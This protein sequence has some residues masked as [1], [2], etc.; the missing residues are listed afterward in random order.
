MSAAIVM[1]YHHFHNH[2][3]SADKNPERQ[4]MI[5]L[6]TMTETIN[7]VKQTLASN[8]QVKVSELNSA[9]QETW[10]SLN[11]SPMLLNIVQISTNS[12]LMELRQRHPSL[13]CGN[14]LETLLSTQI[15]F[16]QFNLEFQELLV[17]C[18]KDWD[19]S[20]IRSKRKLKT[21]GN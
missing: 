21:K 18:Q 10:S 19:S 1:E 11:P 12:L 17:L 3:P 6:L 4:S 20:T 5:Q 2:N 13:L 7:S 14:D 8:P 15:K 16:E 9:I